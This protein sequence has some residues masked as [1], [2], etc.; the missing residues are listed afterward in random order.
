M[1]YGFALMFEPK[2]TVTYISS[3]TVRA[4]YLPHAPSRSVAGTAT[5]AATVD[6]LD[7]LILLELRTWNTAYTRRS[8]VGLLGLDASC[9]A[10]LVTISGVRLRV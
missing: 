3:A 8:K 1:L 2:K 4:K 9:A 7:I 5:S 6:A 10:K